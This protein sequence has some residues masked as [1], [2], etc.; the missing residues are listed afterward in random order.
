MAR[1]SGRWD[2]LL[3][4]A[5]RRIEQAVDGAAGFRDAD[6]IRLQKDWER[7]RSEDRARRLWHEAR[8]K[9]R[10]TTVA[11]VTALAMLAF[12]LDAVPLAVGLLAMAGMLAARAALM[13]AYAAPALPP[14]PAALPPVPRSSQAF[15][16]LTS[17]ASHRTTLI[18]LAPHVPPDIAEASAETAREAERVIAELATAVRGLEV[19]SGSAGPSQALNRLSADLASATAAYEDLVVVVD[20]AAAAG[21]E[22]RT[23]EITARVA[24]IGSA[25][26][27]LRPALGGYGRPPLT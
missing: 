9:G 20:S 18:A 16:P 24:G 1:P 11:L 12:V 15:R 4:V 27:A 5:S 17:V 14:Q 7:A 2:N 6:G 3:E 19:A 26:A 22:T 23:D 25:V 10:W 21:R 8:R 13:P